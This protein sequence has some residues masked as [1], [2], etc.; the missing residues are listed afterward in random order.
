MGATV[1]SAGSKP[2]KVDAD[3]YQLHLSAVFNDAYVNAVYD[4]LPIFE[5]S[6]LNEESAD[7]STNKSDVET[8][9]D[10]RFKRVMA[11]LGPSEIN[12]DTKHGLGWNI[13]SGARE[14]SSFAENNKKRMRLLLR[15]Y[16]VYTKLYLSATK[17][18]VIVSYNCVRRI[19]I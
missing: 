9:Q 19:T 15:I 10:E 7:Q 3:Y 6:N 17:F 8:A 14:Q 4:Q 18:V 16:Q 1:S 5:H 12:G 11:I 13:G 2:D